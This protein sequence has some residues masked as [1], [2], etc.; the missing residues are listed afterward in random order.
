M[1]MS[2]HPAASSTECRRLRARPRCPR[3]APVFRGQT[4]IVVAGQLV[5]R[6]VQ[7]HR[8]PDGLFEAAQRPPPRRYHALPFASS[9][10]ETNSTVSRA[11]Q[12]AV[13]ATLVAT[14]TPVKLICVGPPSYR[15]SASFRCAH[16][17]ASHATPARPSHTQRIVT[18]WLTD[19]PGHRSWSSRLSPSSVAWRRCAGWPGPDRLAVTGTGMAGA[20]T[21]SHRV[22]GIRRTGS[23]ADQAMQPEEGFAEAERRPGP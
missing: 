4:D 13:Y 19:R 22:A 17:I 5:R 2:R 10:P 3:E 20:P 12:S 21:S 23:V 16:A 7:N 6:R 11:R 14:Q 8:R 9:R 18:E 15:G 1:G